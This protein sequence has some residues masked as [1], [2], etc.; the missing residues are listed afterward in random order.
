V[1]ISEMTF[2]R[3]H[4]Y[5]VLRSEDLAESPVEVELFAQKW[6]LWRS[7]DGSARIAPTRCPHRGGSL[8]KGWIDNG[9]LTCPYHGW[10]YAA[11]GP[12]VGIPY[13]DEGAPI[14]SRARLDVR[15]TQEAYGLVWA[16][17]GEPEGP[18]PA[19]IEAEDDTFELHVEFFETSP[20]N[21][22]RMV[23]NAL[24][25]SHIT[26]VHQSTFGIPGE[27][28]IPPLPDVSPTA[29]GF[30]GR[31]TIEIPGVAEQI[32]LDAAE[33]TK[34][35]RKTEIEILSPV[36]VRT[37]FRF[38]EYP[39]GSRDY[40]F[41]MAATPVNDTTCLYV[42]VTALSRADTERDWDQFH[43]FSK[44]VLDEDIVILQ[45]TPGDFS[46]NVLD[47]VHI[48]PDRLTVEYRRHLAALM[49]GARS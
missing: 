42:R 45:H 43:A 12:C 28:I 13:L 36:I 49:A 22:L 4:W 44:R 24:D 32:G 27:L 5:P 8:A 29:A 7:S 25:L 10:Q 16:C 18:V 14:P 39:D 30:L 33:G 41:F 17:V 34:F 19:W 35:E 46:P 26:F 40:G 23:D 47:E 3:D 2:L 6:V 9:N 1:L 15:H 38:T 31:F 37:R 48:R 20:A 21:A 11:D